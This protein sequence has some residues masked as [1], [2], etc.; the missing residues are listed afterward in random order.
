MVSEGKAR[1]RALDPGTGSRVAWVVLALLVF[2]PGR[3]ASATEVP[4]DPPWIVRVWPSSLISSGA[5]P[6]PQI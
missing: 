5:L 2:L 4:F 3:E 1:N 6:D